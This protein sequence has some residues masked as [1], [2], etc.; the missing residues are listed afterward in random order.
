MNW[1]RAKEM[2]KEVRK[3]EQDQP[4]KTTTMCPGSRALLDN[5]GYT[6]KLE[7][8]NYQRQ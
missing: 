1:D 6:H 5:I 8:L 4:R 3:E 7:D 2:K